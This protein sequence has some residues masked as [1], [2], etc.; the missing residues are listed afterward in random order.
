M[1][2]VNFSTKFIH[3]PRLRFALACLLLSCAPALSWAQTADLVA[4]NAGPSTTAAGAPFTYVIKLSNNG[5]AAA[6]GATFVH[7]MPS[8][9]VGVTASC[10]VFSGGATCPSGSNLV[11]TNS[12]VSGTIPIFPN[13]GS[14]EITVTGN[15]GVPSPSSVS[16]TVTLTPPAGVTESNPITNQSTVNTTLITDAKLSVDKVAS[17]V[18]AVTTYTITVKNEGTAAADGDDRRAAAGRGRRPA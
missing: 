6:D 12:Q 14:V 18:G 2:V 5:L 7:S 8:G 11:A 10:T 15:Y 9:A 4:N 1:R 17:T 3:P 16:S 13:Q